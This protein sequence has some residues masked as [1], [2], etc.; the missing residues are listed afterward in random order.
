MLETS[1]QLNTN[2]K[3]CVAYRVAPLPMPLNDLEGHFCGLI[4][5]FLT[6]IA[7]ET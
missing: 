7:R 3:S 5:T 1:L 2:R 4:E 6:P